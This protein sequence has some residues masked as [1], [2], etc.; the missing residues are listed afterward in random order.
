LA[1][2]RR[3]DALGRDLDARR[4][5]KIDDRLDDGVAVAGIVD[6]QGER[7]VDLDPVDI[8]RAQMRERGLAGAEIIEGDANADRAQHF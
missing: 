8:E 4:M 5:G 3:L 7:F 2:V 1:L 6:G